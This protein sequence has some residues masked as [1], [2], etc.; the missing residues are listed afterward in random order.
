LIK[1]TASTP[2]AAQILQSAVQKH[3][4]GDT[5]TAQALYL[6]ILQKLTTLKRTIIWVCWHS[7]AIKLRHPLR[8]L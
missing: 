3:Q 4:S 2:A 5:A 8:I 7:K 1:Q 6:S